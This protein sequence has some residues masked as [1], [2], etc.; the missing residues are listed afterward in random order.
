VGADALSGQAIDGMQLGQQQ[1]LQ[2]LLRQVE[3]QLQLEAPV[4]QQQMQQARMQAA[5]QQ[6]MQ[7]QQA[8][9]LAQAQ[10]QQQQQQ[11]NDLVLA[12]RQMLLGGVGGNQGMASGLGNPSLAAAGY[13]P[14][15][16]QHRGGG[17][18]GMQQ[19]M[20]P[21]L[22]QDASA[23]HR[24]ESFT[25]QCSTSSYV[26]GLETLRAASGSLPVSPLIDR[27]AHS[28]TLAERGAGPFTTLGVVPERPHSFS[29]GDRL[30][31]QQQ[32]AVLGSLSELPA[33]FRLM[34]ASRP[35]SFTLGHPSPNPSFTVERSSA[36]Y[37]VLDSGSHLGLVDGGLSVVER[38]SH[39]QKSFTM[40]QRPQLQQAA[41]PW[42]KT[43]SAAGLLQG[44]PGGDGG[45]VYQVMQ[46]QMQLQEQQQ[47][48]QQVQQ[49]QGGG[50][51]TLGSLFQW[52]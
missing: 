9:L 13:G 21:L 42:Y 47:Q 10:Q 8:L 49:L 24:G 25:S 44:P 29:V 48:Q 30:M 27:S 36:S 17:M 34:D 11:M 26:S 16:L 23:G 38:S 35:N 28:F 45:A 2:H 41:A 4:Q 7:D 51:L 3:Q 37:S 39:T 22:V 6:Q 20:V 46:G 1:E 12:Q 40:G 19:Q 14:A 32:A 15:A 31:Q 33:N 50:R 52:R 5:Q 43:D 18:A